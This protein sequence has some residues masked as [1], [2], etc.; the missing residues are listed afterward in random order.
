MAANKPVLRSFEELFG[1]SGTGPEEIKKKP[2]EGETVL[3]SQNQLK[4]YQRHT[5]SVK[6]SESFAELVM[7]IG[8]YGILEPLLV[9]QLA[10]DSY[11]IISGHRRKRAAELNGIEK[12]PCIIKN[13]ADTRADG[14]MVDTNIHRSEEE[15][16]YSERAF[17]YLLKKESIEAEGSTGKT[18]EKLAEQVKMSR[19]KV[20]RYIRLTYLQPELLQLTDDKRLSFGAAVELSYLQQNDQKTLLSF[21]RE[22]N[23]IPSLAQAEQLRQAGA[24]G[25]LDRS[26]VQDILLPEKKQKPVKVTLQ[27]DTILKYFPESAD[28]KEIERIIVELLEHWRQG[29][30]QRTEGND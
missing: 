23:R 8:E 13:L 24:G 11:E 3:L 26:L 25:G 21:I 27:P 14:V 17:S 10:E 1:G 22:H 4:S 16:S 19:N 28:G 7:S 6:D 20:H 2:S 5:F 18:Y 29:N 30:G 12:I 9:R 15:I